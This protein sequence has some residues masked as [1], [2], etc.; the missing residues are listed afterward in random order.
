[1]LYTALCLRMKVLHINELFRDLVQLFDAPAPVIQV[2]K[3]VRRI[4][5][6]IHQGCGIHMGFILDPAF[7]Q[8]DGKWLKPS[9][10]SALLEAM[11]HSG[12]RDVV[13]DGILA[14]TIPERGHLRISGP[15]LQAEYGVLPAGQDLMQD[16][17]AEV[18][19]VENDQISPLQ[20]CQMFRHT[21]AFVFMSASSKS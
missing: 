5:G 19:P 21:A 8:S 4:T 6:L 17:V 7:H 2:R 3:T 10:G 15:L 16:L 18:T 12:R 20:F 1:M 14:V 13:D 11:F 9:S